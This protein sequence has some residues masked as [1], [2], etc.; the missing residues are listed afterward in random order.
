MSNLVTVLNI[1]N[2]QGKVYSL[3]LC[4]NTKSVNWKIKLSGSTFKT[5]FST[6]D[7]LKY[8]AKILYQKY[9]EKGYPDLQR[10]DEKGLQTCCIP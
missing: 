6:Q 5:F 8:V 7:I 10:V 9:P 4:R 1:V 3:W 2:Y